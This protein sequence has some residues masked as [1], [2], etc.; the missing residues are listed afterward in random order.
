[1]PGTLDP[2]AVYLP[3]TPILPQLAAHEPGSPSFSL[4]LPTPPRPPVGK[5]RLRYLL[6]ARAGKHELEV[7]LLLPLSFLPPLCLSLLCKGGDH[8]LLPGSGFPHLACIAPASQLPLPQSLSNP[9]GPYG[10]TPPP[11]SWADTWVDIRG[12]YPR[13]GWL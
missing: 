1:M 10:T 9:L 4:I 5:L 12:S 8:F 2:P 3:G 11:T 13:G 6:L 7:Q